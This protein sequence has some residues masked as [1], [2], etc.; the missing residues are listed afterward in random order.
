ME[1]I[2][3]NPRLLVSNKYRMLGF[4]LIVLQVSLAQGETS[5]IRKSP[6]REDLSSLNA[7]IKHRSPLRLEAVVRSAFTSFPA[8]L[9]A[10]NKREM[11]RGEKRSAEGGF[12]TI[13]KMYSRSSLAGQYQNE[14]VDIGFEQPTD[15]YGVSFFGGYRRGIGNYPVYEGK[16]ATA[17]AGEV[18]AGIN[19][20]LWRNREVDRRRTNLAQSELSQMMASHEYDHQ[21]L[22]LER[23]ATYRYWD[24]VL[25]GRRSTIAKNLLD[26]AISRNEAIHQRIKLGDLAAIDADENQRAVLERR[27]RLIAAERGLE[28]AAIQLSLYLRSPEGETLMPTVEDLPDGFPDAQSHPHQ[29]IE[30][31][32]ETALTNRPD[33]RRLEQN[34]RHAELEHQLARNQNQ[35]NV[36]LVI[37]GAQDFGVSQNY[38][39][40]R[41][42]FYAG[43]SIDIPVQQRVAEGKSITAEANVLRLKADLTLLED[44]IRNEIKDALSAINASYKRIQ[45]AEDHRQI[46]TKLEDAEKSRYELGESN[47]M[48]VNLRELATGDAA[49]TYADALNG[50]HRALADFRFAS[51]DFTHIRENEKHHQFPTIDYDYDPTS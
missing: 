20:P 26:L 9:A 17:T 15:F 42:E 11:A 12:D 39:V 4:I 30:H 7:Q 18:R 3:N 29:N 48:I 1:A 31:L 19:I 35:P 8:V 16:S 38:L 33:L 43:V 40:N 32:I 10:H 36:D 50:Y 23:Q 45:I 14:N 47:L 44:R 6:Y 41:S 2:K 46:A 5:N 24:W 21:L 37:S 49:L 28:Q 51:G 22:D 25:A 13:L 27:E 34:I